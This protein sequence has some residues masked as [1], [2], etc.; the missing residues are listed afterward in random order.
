MKPIINYEGNNLYL[1]QDE[2]T[3][4]GRVYLGLVKKNGELFED[5]TINLPDVELNDDEICLNSNLQR[6]LKNKLY[7]TDIFMNMF[8]E[9]QYNMGKYDVVFINK[10]LIS[11]Y[12]YDDEREVTNE[13]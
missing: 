6:D 10:N 5:I 2:Y 3:I 4:N 1:K 12:R 9:E 11:E 7:E 8:R 13:L